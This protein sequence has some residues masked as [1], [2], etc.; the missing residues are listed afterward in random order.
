[1]KTLQSHDGKYYA[2]LASANGAQPEVLLARE[3]IALIRSRP[4]GS[5]EFLDDVRE[6]P[7]LRIVAVVSNERP[8]QADF[9][10]KVVLVNDL[11]QESE[12]LVE[13]VAPLL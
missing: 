5:M 12:K 1:M 4:D 11:Y 3:R 7:G 6:E 9:A 2:S 8:G 13:A 10:D